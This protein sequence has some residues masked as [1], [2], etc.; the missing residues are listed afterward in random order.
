MGR[1]R[2]VLDVLDFGLKPNK[3]VDTP[4]GPSRRISRFCR[5]IG[6]LG[7]DFAEFDFLSNDIHDKTRIPY[8]STRFAF[9]IVVVVFFSLHNR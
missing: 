7:R 9:S 3:A 6:L 8:F 2:M 5:P 1:K 4:G